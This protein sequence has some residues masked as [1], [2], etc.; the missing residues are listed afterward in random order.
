LLIGIYYQIGQSSGVA[1]ALAL[2]KNIPL[3]DLPIAELQ[4]AITTQGV[5][6]HYDTQK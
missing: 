4:A 3:H 2:N 6:I 5:K 1:A